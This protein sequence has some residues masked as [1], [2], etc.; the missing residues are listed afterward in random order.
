MIDYS[1]IPEALNERI[2]FIRKKHGYKQI[3]VA[4]ILKVSRVTYT[5]YETGDR[6]IPTEV[7][8]GLAKIYSLTTDF[9]LGIS[10]KPEPVDYEDFLIGLSDKAIKNLTFMFNETKNTFKFLNCILESTCSFEILD[11]LETL[12]KA[13][14][15]NKHFKQGEIKI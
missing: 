3:E 6:T 10:A 15:S 7:I 12:M 13:T 14:L 5:K 2:Q 11:S 8:I 9:I 4:Q 1:G